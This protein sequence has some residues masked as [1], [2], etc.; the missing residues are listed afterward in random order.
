[1]KTTT[2]VSVLTFRPMTPA[3]I[4]AEMMRSA[5]Q[6]RLTSII[7]GGGCVQGMISATAECR[8]NEI[9]PRRR[10]RHT[11][12]FPMPDL[13]K[14]ARKTRHGSRAAKSLAK[15]L[16]IKR[17]SEGCF[18]AAHAGIIYAEEAKSLNIFAQNALRFGQKFAVYTL[19]AAWVEFGP[20]GVMELIKK[21]SLKRAQSSGKCFRKMELILNRL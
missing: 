21:L 11:D 20:E 5:S 13:P 15:G 8:C 19:R 16:A 2:I 14:D 1:M 6:N 12:P 4:D 18:Q 9:D 3:A 10:G 17:K 7:H